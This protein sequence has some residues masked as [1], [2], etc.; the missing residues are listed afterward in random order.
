MFRVRVKRQKFKRFNQKT[1]TKPRERERKREK[2]EEKERRKKD[3]GTFTEISFKSL[4]NIELN[5]RSFRAGAF[6]REQ[7]PRT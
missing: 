1:K 5:R 6:A 7:R 2:E 4:C 3:S